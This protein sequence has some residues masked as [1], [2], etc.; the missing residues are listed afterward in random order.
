MRLCWAASDGCAFLGASIGAQ[1]AM[2]TSGQ[3]EHLELA[4]RPGRSEA[5]APS[6]PQDFGT[7]ERSSLRHQESGL[8]LTAVGWQIG[9]DN[10]CCLGSLKFWRKL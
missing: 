3:C 8:L 7:K 1:D 10:A 6:G 2:A 9:T 4:A 5:C